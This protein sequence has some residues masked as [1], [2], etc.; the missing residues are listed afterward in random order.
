MISQKLVA[1]DAKCYSGSAKVNGQ[2]SG[3]GTSSWDFRYI[4]A[5]VQQADWTT[6]SMAYVFPSKCK[7]DGCNGASLFD[8]AKDTGL[9]QAFFTHDV[10][11]IVDNGNKQYTTAPP[12]QL[13]VTYDQLGMIKESGVGSKYMLFRAGEDLTNCWTKNIKQTTIV[14]SLACIDTILQME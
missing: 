3:F 14:R 1:K 11:Y 5:D 9:S 12:K 2:P 4:W 13:V 10:Y 6:V 7:N 8:E